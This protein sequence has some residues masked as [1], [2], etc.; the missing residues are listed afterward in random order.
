MGRTNGRAAGALVRAVSRVLRFFGGSSERRVS[1]QCVVVCDKDEVW[2]PHRCGDPAPYVAH[3]ASAVGEPH[4]YRVGGK[5]V[6]SMAGIARLAAGSSRGG[7]ACC[8][9][10]AR[11]ALKAGAI[12]VDTTGERIGFDV[13]GNLRE[14]HS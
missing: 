8:D 1:N 6:L 13:N 2:Y 14:V 5:R 3:A 4:S 7:L 9:E 10:H 11:M 12:V